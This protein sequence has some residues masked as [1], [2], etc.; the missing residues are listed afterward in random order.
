MNQPPRF[1]IR[2]GLVQGA[3][4]TV[5]A[6]ATAALIALSSAGRLG[7]AGRLAVAAAILFVVALLIGSARAIGLTTLPMLGAAIAAFSAATQQLWIQSIVIGILWYIASESAWDAIERRG[8]ANRSPAL[9]NRRAFE[10][11]T[12][13][14]I[15]LTI[16]SVGFL[17]SNIAPTRTLLTVGLVVVG[18]FVALGLAT[19]HVDQAGPDTG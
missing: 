5:A 7:F 8:G 9:N 18:L 6:G 4:A 3:V 16:T 17:A 15:S 14:T 1:L 2:D 11:S 10:V 12:V 13:V 19:R